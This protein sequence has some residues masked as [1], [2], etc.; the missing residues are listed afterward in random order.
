M[1]RLVIG[2]CVGVMA[3][4]NVRL[5][6][7][8]QIDNQLVQRL[9]SLFGPMVY[10]AQ[11]KIAGKYLFGTVPR[12]MLNIHG[13]PLVLS[14]RSVN[15]G[16]PQNH[17]TRLTW[18]PEQVVRYSTTDC[19]GPPLITDSWSGLRPVVFVRD[20]SGSLIAHI[21]SDVPSTPQLAY[22]YIAP[23]TLNCV[24]DWRTVPT[25]PLERTVNI[26]ALYPETLT[27]R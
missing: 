23:A 2:L 12:A 16:G 26:D 6:V 1:K 21:A 24:E 5:A 20:A 7:A 27:I 4:F 8:Q 10:D 15:S 11:G 25:Y 14:M 18:Y 22:S 3:V 13:I 17:P 19:S 9:G